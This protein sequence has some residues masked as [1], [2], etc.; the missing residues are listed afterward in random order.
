VSAGRCFA[1]DRPLGRDPRRA[2]TRDGQRVYVGRDCLRKIVAAGEEGYQPP[3]GG[4]L[5]YL[6]SAEDARAE[7]VERMARSRAARFGKS[8]IAEMTVTELELR[9]SMATTL[10]AKARWLRKIA[11][12]GLAL[13]PAQAEILAREHARKIP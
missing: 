11:A 12:R 13:S 3:A 1:C 9:A 6:L 10:T 7:Q 5:L 2:D 4:P 8:A